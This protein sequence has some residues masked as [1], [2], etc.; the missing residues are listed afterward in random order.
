MSKLMEVSDPDYVPKNEFERV[1]KFVA[2]CYNQYMSAVYD[3]GFKHSEVA[4]PDTY[5]ERLARAIV[6]IGDTH[7]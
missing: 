6:K 5:L 4:I 1:L 3:D 7:V 2:Y